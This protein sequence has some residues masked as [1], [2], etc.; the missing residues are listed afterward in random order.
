MK[1]LFKYLI[2]AIIAAGCSSAK[3]P[4]KI[5]FDTDFGGDADDLGALAMLHNLADHGE[6]E[7]AAIMCWSTE[8]SAIPAIDAVN[9]WYA[10]PD[11]P[12]G[13]RKE[14]SH[15]AQWNYNS[16]IAQNFEN[17]LT[18][19]MVPGTTALYRKILSSSSEHSIT[20]ITVGPLKNIQN[21][22]MSEGDEYSPLSGKELLESKVKEVV[23]MGG[24]FP[25]GENEW[26]FNGNMPGVTPY[27]LDNLEVPLVFTGFEVGVKLK[28]GAALNER[29]ELTPL[30]TGFS[31]FSQYA[32][33]IKQNYK[34]KILDNS[35]FDQSAVLYAVRNG[36]GTYWEKVE[37][38]RCLADDK[39]GNSWIP[40]EESSHSYLKL[41]MPADELAGLIEAIMLNE[42]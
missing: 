23:I 31:H 27:V 14:G 11:I 2:I 9:R 18:P 21:L 15:V 22:L 10:H 1:N 33:W 12:L 37:G 26:N 39:G 4:V 13:L 36:V 35:S 7:L 41:T 19:D 42:F 20:I 28:T 16:V 40:M 34:G 3:P 8:E 24:N 25:S 38:G 30:Q 6:C 17:H 29:D 32:P 5:I